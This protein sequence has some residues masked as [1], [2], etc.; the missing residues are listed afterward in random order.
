MD[1]EKVCMQLGNNGKNMFEA[2]SH[3]LALSEIQKMLFVSTI[4]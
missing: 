1:N 4:K 3:F 2:I